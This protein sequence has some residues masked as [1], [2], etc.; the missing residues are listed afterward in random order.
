MAHPKKQGD[1]SLYWIIEIF[2]L[3][4]PAL[5]WLG[6]L[7]KTL[8]YNDAVLVLLVGQLP[9]DAMRTIAFMIICPLAAAGLSIDFVRHHQ[10][11]DLASS[12]SKMIVITALIS[13]LIVSLYL[14]TGNYQCLIG[15]GAGC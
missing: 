5:M 10:K 11:K 8:F 4:P 15:N 13:V 3:L 9:G 1:A 12:L 2:L 6:V 14:F 7:T